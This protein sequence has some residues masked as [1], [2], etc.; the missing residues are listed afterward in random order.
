MPT[1]KEILEKYT[2][3]LESDVNAYSDSQTNISQEY[4]KFKQEMIPELSRY[5]RLAKSLGNIIKIKISQK[6]RE[7]VQKYL[8][9]AGLDV[10]ASESLTLSI[11]SMLGIF[12]ISILTTVALYL[13]LK[14]DKLGNLI[15][16]VF[17]GLMASMFARVKARGV[18]CGKDISLPLLADG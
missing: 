7:K 8:D 2:R 15:L 17:L 3:K 14:P 1:T 16:F 18:C 10:S 11:I 4:I 6:D 9:I 5:E 13:I 12:F